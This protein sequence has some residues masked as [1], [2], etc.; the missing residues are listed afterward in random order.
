MYVCIY[1]FLS[2]KMFDDIERKREW[3]EK[4]EAKRRVTFSSH[5]VVQ[6]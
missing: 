6:S 5:A 4:K 2:L 3:G 1:S